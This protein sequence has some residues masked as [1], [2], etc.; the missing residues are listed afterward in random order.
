MSDF[1]SSRQHLESLA[2][3]YSEKQ[4]NINE[5]TT[6]LMMIDK[7]F[8]ECLG[9]EKDDV[10]LEESENKEYSDYTF[11]APRRILIVEAK[12]T[13]NYFNI[14]IE[15]NH[16]EYALN[17]LTKEFGNIKSAVEQVMRYCQQRGV[18]NAVVT[19]GHQL[20]AFI[21]VKSDGT[22]PLQGKALVFSSLDLMLENFTEFW[23]SLSKEGIQH[24]YLIQKLS[25]GK[26][27]TLPQKLSASIFNYPGN[28]RRNIFQTDLQIV[29]EL[30]FEDLT[31]SVELESQFLEECYCDS[32]ALSQYSLASKNIL[33]A[34]YS[35]LFDPDV[36]SPTI[37]SANSKKGITSTILSESLSRR[38]ILLIG[39]VGV[40][41]TTFIRNLIKVKADEI[42]QNSI[43][44][45]IDLGSQGNFAEKIKDF[46]LQEMASQ[47]LQNYGIDIHESNFIKGVYDKKIERFKKSIYGD[48]IESNH[49]LYIEKEI[50]YIEKLISNEE[51]HL[52]FS[53]EHIEKARKRQVVIIIDN[54]D[55]RTEDVQQ[56]AFLIAEELAAHW[57]ATVF[58]ALRPETY[59]HSL[60][61]GALSGYHP[62]AYTIDPPRIDLVLRKR[63]D[64][65]LKITS[66]DIK[67]KKLSNETSVKLEKLGSIIQVFINSLNYKDDLMQFIDNI[68]AGNVRVALDLVKN[69][70]GSGHVNTEKIIKI[71][72]ET[73]SYLIPL[74]EF[75][76]AV[77]YGDNE[78]FNSQIFN[79]IYNVF[80][81]STNDRKEHF[82][83]PLIIA[84]LASYSFKT[85][86]DGFKETSL[87]YEQL[88]GLGFTAEQIDL[89]I[90]RGCSDKLIETAGRIIPKKSEDI[91]QTLRATTIGLYH[92]NKLIN[93]FT[94]VDAVVVDTIILDKDIYEKICN[95]Q[96]IQLRLERAQLFRS[97]LDDCW[98]AVSSAKPIFDWESKSLEL[99]NEIQNI[100]SKLQ[101]KRDYSK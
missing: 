86:Q 43:T 70:F 51:T 99:N 88:Q 35:S 28:Q 6:R 2:S 34:R 1:E 13:G 14:P 53:L 85:E 92:I 9:W 48:L 49:N 10:I 16:I 24:K 60:K 98:K 15:K 45:Y 77:I 71:Y 26:I 42:F 55:Q 66:G 33:K 101:Q 67:I 32:G 30:V 83:E 64:F 81:I 20:L 61:N 54:A 44:L 100:K 78:Y 3:W 41:K 31:G 93:M 68:S 84:I 25:G 73:G 96:D 58:V 52:K 5:S 72:D 91:P 56:Q 17:S 19:N 18:P 69:F 50:E 27:I 29:S 8:F 76:R 21:A 95:V 12:K 40:G 80:E 4:P 11:Q 22:S 97:Y 63:L 74:H 39:D 62:K 79:N 59:H 89:A 38:P 82:I 57:P 37:I 94:Y 36:S 46:V 65:A 90:I 47:L 87:V 23:N 7:L 75:L